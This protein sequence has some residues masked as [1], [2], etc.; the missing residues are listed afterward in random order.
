MT[1]TSIDYGIDLGTTNSAVAVL[2]GTT[3]EVIAR[4]DGSIVTPSAI[5][6]DKRGQQFIGQ[7]A[8]GNYFSDEENG[9]IEFKLHMGEE[10]QRTFQRT[11]HKMLPEEM[12]AEILKSLKDDVQMMKGED[13]KA[14]VIT[15]PAAFELP[16]CEATRR[17][18]KL[19]GLTISPLLQE[20]IAAALAYGF[21][22]AANKVFWLVYDFGGGTFDAAVIQ[23]RDGVLQ[24]VNH[25]GHNYLGGKNIDWEIV[26]KLLIPRLTKEWKLTDFTRQNPKWR[27][28]IAKAEVIR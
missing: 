27:S 24:V 11:G 25:A 26:D 10:W 8:R 5:W 6:F 17:A 22:S 19:A 23:V 12:S 13:L 20:P 9:A 16:Q 15:V 4:V 1:R 14:A 3:P 2:V 18:A 28:A 21:Q 7:K